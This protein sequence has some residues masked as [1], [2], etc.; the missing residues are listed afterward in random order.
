T[1]SAMPAVAHKR[2]SCTW[3]DYLALDED[4]RR[5]LIDGDLVGV[6]VSP[7]RAHE[8]IASQLAYFITLWGKSARR[9]GQVLASGYKVRI[10][11][12]R[13]VQPDVQ[14]YRSD[15]PARRGQ[16]AGLIDG[17]PD[18]VVEVISPSSRR[19]DRVIKLGYY[20]SVAVP[21]YWIIDPDARTVE[22]LVLVAGAY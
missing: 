11:E 10:S 1:Q 20:Q 12:R 19:Y 15:T 4:D 16:D 6:E 3:D 9:G 5:E 8:H 18:L 17:H 7:T 13:G 14:Y 21:E 22:R 2:G